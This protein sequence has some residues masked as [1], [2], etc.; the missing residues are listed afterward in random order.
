MGLLSRYIKKQKSPSIRMAIF[1]LPESVYEHSQIVY[2][3]KT[4]NRTEERKDS[5]FAEI[6]FR[7]APVPG[8]CF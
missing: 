6:I 1:I 3:S 4:V 8:N 2:I 5:R 7:I